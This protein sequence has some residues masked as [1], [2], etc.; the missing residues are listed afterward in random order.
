[1]EKGL[2]FEFDNQNPFRSGLLITRSRTNPRKREFTFRRQFE[3]TKSSDLE[4]QTKERKRDPSAKPRTTD[5]AL[6][7]PPP[8]ERF[9]LTLAH[10]LFQYKG[11]KKEEE[12]ENEKEIR[13][14]KTLTFL[15]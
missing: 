6:F 14:K 3:E 7:L 15:W 11:Q 9:G 5:N 1:M 12:E 10:S 2:D 13:Q 8:I 4:N